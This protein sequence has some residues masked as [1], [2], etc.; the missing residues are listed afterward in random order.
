MNSKEPLSGVFTPVVSP[1]FCHFQSSFTRRGSLA[2]ISSMAC[3]ADD[4]THPSITQ[5][6][7]QRP[8]EGNP[9]ITEQVAKPSSL[10]APGRLHCFS[11]SLESSTAFGSQNPSAAQGEVFIICGCF[12]R[13]I[14]AHAQGCVRMTGGAVSSFRF[15]PGPAVSSSVQR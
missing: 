1:N 5:I 3:A 4:S 11:C 12:E 8:G 6:T 14:L 7:G 10:P 2:S 13:R 9:G 15:M